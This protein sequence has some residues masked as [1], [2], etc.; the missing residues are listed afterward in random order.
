MNYKILY[1]ESKELDDGSFVYRVELIKDIKHGTTGT[2]GGWIAQG[3]NLVENAWVSD[4]AMIYGKAVVSGDAL[5]SDNAQVA[6]QARVSMRAK[7]S[8]N[9]I[10]SGRSSIEDDAEI[11]DNC[12]VGGQANVKGTTIL[13]DDCE[14]WG[15]ARVLEGTWIESPFQAWGPNEYFVTECRPGHLH[16]GCETKTFE[17]WITDGYT[18]AKKKKN[19]NH[20]NK[21]AGFIEPLIRKYLKYSKDNW[22]ELGLI[23]KATYHAV[24]LKSKAWLKEQGRDDDSDQYKV[25]E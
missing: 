5:V 17:K 1:E 24:M 25:N 8:G 10:I 11:T 13:K 9:A 16:I 22:S 15:K 4:E 23:Q 18:F 20:Y 12:T 2:K 21:Y 7:V 3:I 19:D 6:G 14:I